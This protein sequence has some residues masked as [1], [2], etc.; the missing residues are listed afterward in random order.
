MGEIVNL[1]NQSEQK[2]VVDEN[3]T[4]ESVGEK[5]SEE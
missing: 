5:D 3:V 1:T 2:D 4:E